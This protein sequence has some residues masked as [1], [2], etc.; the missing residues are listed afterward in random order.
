MF[1]FVSIMLSIYSNSQAITYPE[2]FLSKYCESETPSVVFMGVTPYYEESDKSLTTDSSSVA[3]IEGSSPTDKCDVV[4]NCSVIFV[5]PK[6]HALLVHPLSVDNGNNIGSLSIFVDHRLKW[7]WDDS[8]E[9]NATPGHDLIQSS[10][11]NGIVKISVTVEKVTTTWKHFTLDI[12]L[13]AF[14]RKRRRF[15]SLFMNALTLTVVEEAIIC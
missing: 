13:T 14:I 11:V 12:L 3:H 6:D 10:R 8:H 4:K 9:F 2:F 5:P 7:Y 1:L 15:M